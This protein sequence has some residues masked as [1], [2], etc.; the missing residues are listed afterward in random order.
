MRPLDKFAILCLSVLTI[1]LVLMLAGGV[2]T[3]LIDA[4]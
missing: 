4:Q 3:L 2:M 1:T